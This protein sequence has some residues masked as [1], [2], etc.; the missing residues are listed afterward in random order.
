MC[1]SA[2]SWLH[3]KRPG[4]RGKRQKPAKSG[5]AV[6]KAGPYVRVWTA[7]YRSG[8]IRTWVGTGP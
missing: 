7:R 5:N 3:A 4:E 6:R 2:V 8:T 1:E